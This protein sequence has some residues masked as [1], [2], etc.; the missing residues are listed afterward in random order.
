M[1]Q[2]TVDYSP[3][4]R[5]MKSPQSSIRRETLRSEAKSVMP[6]AMANKIIKPGTVLLRITVVSMA[7]IVAG[8]FNLLGI[9]DRGNRF[10]VF[11]IDEGNQA[12][13]AV[14]NPLPVFPGSID[15]DC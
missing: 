15:I 7:V 10:D 4:D 5:A 3:K 14:P 2:G 8:G 11:A 1:R 12:P 13:S 6:S 9:R